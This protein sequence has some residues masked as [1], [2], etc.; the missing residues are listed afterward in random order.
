MCRT[1]LSNIGGD[2]GTLCDHAFDE[3]LGSTERWECLEARDQRR[4]RHALTTRG[5]VLVRVRQVLGV[6][7]LAV[8][9]G[10]EQLSCSQALH[11]P[12]LLPH[13]AERL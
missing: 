8:V 9:F 7:P 2:L 3:V 1:R 5:T 13:P 12:H 6:D 4:E 11:L 10:H